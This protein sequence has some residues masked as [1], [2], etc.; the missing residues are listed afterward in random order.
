MN[1]KEAA[2][3]LRLNSMTVYRLAQKRQLPAFKVGGNWR[4]KK[5]LLD[6]WMAEK[7]SSGRGSILI[8]DDDLMILDALREMVQGQ[9]YQ[10]FTAE[11]GELALEAIEK[12]KFDLILLDLMLP[13]LKGVELLESIKRKDKDVVVVVITGYADDPIALQAMALGPLLLVRKPFRENDIIEALS[14]V[15]KK[16]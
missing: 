10:A 4:F 16:R 8:V 11:T 13:G 2:V 3:Y 7:V 5:Q 14:I 9:G 12:R 1:I 15:M 6:N